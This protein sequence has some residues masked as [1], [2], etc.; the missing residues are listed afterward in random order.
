MAVAEATAHDFS[1][2]WTSREPLRKN[3]VEWVAPWHRYHGKARL[4]GPLA[5]VYARTGVVVAASAMAPAIVATLNMC[6]TAP[7]SARWM[8]GLCPRLLSGTVKAFTLPSDIFSFLEHASAHEA[9]GTRYI[10]HALGRLAD[11]FVAI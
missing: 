7:V 11:L 9:S 1:G 10:R 2:L 5:R 8:T 3:G 6:G 4:N